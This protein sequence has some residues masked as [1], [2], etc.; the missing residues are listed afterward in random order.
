MNLAPSGF[1]LT[2][3]LFALL[4]PPLSVW[5]WHRYRA[6]VDGA[7][8]TR[9]RVAMA[10]LGVSTLLLL[11]RIASLDRLDPLL[12]STIAWQTFALWVATF[13]TSAVTW[14]LVTEKHVN[15][16]IGSLL[17]NVVVVLLWGNFAEFGYL[18]RLTAPHTGPL[19][20]WLMIGPPLFLASRGMPWK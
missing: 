12:Q 13:T 11:A 15:A 8:S 3:C 10:I 9:L 7:R 6:S 16:G 1:A 2:A 14:S 17:T 5:L 19:G 4:A 18:P 20:W